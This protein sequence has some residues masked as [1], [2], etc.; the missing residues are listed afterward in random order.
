M[1]L[2]NASTASTRFYQI[3][4]KLIAKSE[5]TAS[6]TNTSALGAAFTGIK[7]QA[8][9]DDKAVGTDDHIVKRVK[10]LRQTDKSANT[11]F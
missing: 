11:F 1:G 2:K 8:P 9:L 3:K 5:P 7:R 6:S 4:K 10:S